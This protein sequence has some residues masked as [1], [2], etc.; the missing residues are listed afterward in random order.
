M[1]GKHFLKPIPVLSLFLPLFPFSSFTAAV[2][3]SSK[4]QFVTWVYSVLPTMQFTTFLLSERESDPTPS[5][6]YDICSDALLKAQQVGKTPGLCPDDSPFM[7]SYNECYSCLLA[8]AE[9]DARELIKAELDPTFSPYI[10]YC[11]EQKNIDPS[12]YTSTTTWAIATYTN[13]NRAP[14]TV[15]V[16]VDTTV[17]RPDWTGFQT[18]TSMSPATTSQTVTTASLTPDQHK[19]K[20]SA[21]GPRPWVWA[22]IGA[23]IA[24]AVIGLGVLQFL[25]RK[26][27]LRF[28]ER[29]LRMTLAHP[30]ELDGDLTWR[31]GD[32]PELHGQ[33]SSMAAAVVPSKELYTPNN[34]PKEL[35]SSVEPVELPVDGTGMRARV[36]GL[37]VEV[38]LGS[39][40][41]RTRDIVEAQDGGNP[42]EKRP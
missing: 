8:N 6:C 35:D 19:T 21:S 36:G 13:Q 11:Q 5:Q 31:T 25:Y 2:C 15:T 26:G 1:E 9:E 14:V 33:S 18:T 22:I 37:P 38:H 24:L 16:L 40:E 41:G 30:H 28:I 7:H 3:V 42:R 39:G 34:E 32:K 4:S 27:K 10:S 29:K 20:D 17:L 12:W 23:V